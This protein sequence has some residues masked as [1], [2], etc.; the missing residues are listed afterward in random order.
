VLFYDFSKVEDGVVRDGS[1]NGHALQ[2]PDGRVFVAPGFADL[3]LSPTS[4]TDLLINLLGF[5]PFG[6][7][8]SLWLSSRGNTRFNLL[9]VCFCSA[10][11]SASIELSQAWIP[12]RDSSLLD[13][14]LNTVGTLAGVGLF[15][16]IASRDRARRT[17][18]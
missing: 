7:L 18:G 15:A 10:L 14:L 11:L 16:V 9:V 5:V 1:G 2:I 3:E 17:G 8:L 12:T 6:F 4:A 13:F